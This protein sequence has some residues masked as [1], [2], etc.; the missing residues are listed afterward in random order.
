MKKDETKAIREQ[1]D[2]TGY[3]EHSVPLFLTSSFVY[4][5]AEQAQSMFAGEQEGDIYSRFTNPN[6]TELINKVCML[7]E[8]ED[9]VATSSGM[10][11]IFATLSALLESGD[12]LVAGNSL[13]GNSLYIIQQIL[14]KW[15]ITYTLV[16]VTRTAA[17]EAAIL[18]NTKLLLVESPTNPG[19]DLVDIPAVSAICKA[20]NILFVVDNC[21]ATPILQKPMIMGADIVTH[22]ATKWMDGQGRVLGGLVVGHKEHIAKIFDF[23]RRTGACLSPFNA[24]LLSKSLETL[25]LRMERHCQNALHLAS[26]LSSHQQIESVKYP[27]LSSHPQYALAKQMMTM[28]GGIVTCDIKGGQAAAFQFINHLKLLSNTANLGDSRTIVTHPAT[29]THSK[30]SPADRAQAGITEATVRISVGLEAIAD[31]IADIEQ[32]L[33]NATYE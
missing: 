12:H 27:F 2:R 14:P 18:S 3:R 28:G 16:D 8:A 10:A 6:T 7:E 25:S 4:D 31:I 1:I 22:S 30:L 29:T 19:L 11:G 20:Q 32:A 17:V 13:F 33:K 5:S 26:Y 23:L 21:F 9:G 15:G 24:W